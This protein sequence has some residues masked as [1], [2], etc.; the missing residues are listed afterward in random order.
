M[1]KI[2]LSRLFHAISLSVTDLP[3]T[4]NLSTNPLISKQH[5][6]AKWKEGRINRINES[7][8]QV[9]LLRIWSLDIMHIFVLTNNVKNMSTAPRYH[10]SMSAFVRFLYMF[11]TTQS[12]SD[13]LYACAWVRLRI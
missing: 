5:P 12:M 13:I 1:E 2:Y 6:L 4:R 9:I 10:I 7:T 3:E 8:D 11:R